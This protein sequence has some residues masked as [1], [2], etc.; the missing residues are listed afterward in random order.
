MKK[1]TNALST[2]FRCG[3][4]LPTV[5]EWIYAA[6]G[7]KKSKGYKYSGSNDINEVAWYKANANI[8]DLP[9]TVVWRDIYWVIYESDGSYGYADYKSYFPNRIHCNM[10]HKKKANELGLYDMSGNAAEIAVIDKSPY[11][12]DNGKYLMLGGSV[13]S[14][15]NECV[16]GEAYEPE[17]CALSY[18]FRPDP[19]WKHVYGWDGE[20]WYPYPC[21]TTGW[22]EYLAVGL[23]LVLTADPQLEASPVVTVESD[24]V[25][26]KAIEAKMSTNQ[27]G[28]NKVVNNQNIQ[29]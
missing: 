19:G 25:T 18:R 2:H 4:R 16:P 5:E 14:D 7:G 6:R 13:R 27:I 15:E 24:I 12:Y 8:Q 10:S 28:D 22:Q 3:F 20:Y 21:T 26:S 9:D 11:P 17:Q 23:R 29:P 1:F